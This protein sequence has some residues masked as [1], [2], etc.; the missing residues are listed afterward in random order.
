MFV[1]IVISPLFP[2]FQRTVQSL[3]L[4]RQAPSVEGPYSRQPFFVRFMHA[5][6]TIETLVERLRKA[7]F[8]DESIALHD[9]GQIVSM[10]RLDDAHP[11]RQFHI[12][13]FTDGEIR[14]HYEFTPEDH[15][16]AHWNE[17]LFTP[18]DQFMTWLQ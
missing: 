16:I 8:Y 6:E 5:T 7:G 3:G 9:P 18:S 2:F 14:G 11:D 15:P 4:L 1:R 17:T 12:R 10:R 13:I